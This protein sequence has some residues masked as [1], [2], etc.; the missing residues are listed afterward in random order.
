VIYEKIE[1]TR[2]GLTFA[3]CGYKKICRGFAVRGRGGG[4]SAIPLR[5][6]RAQLDILTEG[7]RNG[8]AASNRRLAQHS[9]VTDSLADESRGSVGLR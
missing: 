7:N 4:S 3:W 6:R 5:E 2:E 8:C 9:S 1:E